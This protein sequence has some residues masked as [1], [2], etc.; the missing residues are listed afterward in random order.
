[1]NPK[2]GERGLRSHRH[3]RVRG[4][5]WRPFGRGRRGIVL[6][7]EGREVLEPSGRTTG[8]TRYEL[9]HAGGD[10]RARLEGALNHFENRDG[11]QSARRRMS[12]RPSRRG[13][14]VG[15]GERRGCPEGGRPRAERRG[16]PSRRK[17]YGSLV[18]G[19]VKSGGKGREILSKGRSHGRRS[20]QFDIR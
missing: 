7:G 20:R 16:S 2:H 19:Y 11:S 5:S 6:E 13:S 15:R 3:H 9:R 12:R 8:R 18:G 1:M 4:R 10:R 14:F 17:R